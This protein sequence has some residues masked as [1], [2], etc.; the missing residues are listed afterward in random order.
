[1][2]KWKDGTIKS[3]GNAFDWKNYREGDSIVCDLQ[4]GALHSIRASKV[5]NDKRMK[6]VDISHISGLSKKPSGIKKNMKAFVVKP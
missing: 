2:K 5:V 6:G 1:M 4:N 3:T